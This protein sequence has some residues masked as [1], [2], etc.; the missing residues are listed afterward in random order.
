MINNNEDTNNSSIDLT[1]D[2]EMN[3]VNNEIQ[4]KDHKNI[5]NEKN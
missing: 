3:F 5:I 1:N 2:K 4:E